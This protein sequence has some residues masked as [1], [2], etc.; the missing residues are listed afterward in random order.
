MKIGHIGV[1]YTAL[2]VLLDDATSSAGSGRAGASSGGRG[3]DA[4]GRSPGGGS[5]GS[6]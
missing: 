5:R 1:T 4:S 6:H 2:S 3:P